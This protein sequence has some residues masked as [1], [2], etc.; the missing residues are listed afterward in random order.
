MIRESRC[1]QGTEVSSW[2]QTRPRTPC[3]RRIRAASVLA[4]RGSHQCHACATV[5]RSK[6][7]RGQPGLLGGALDGVHLRQGPAQLVQHVRGRVDGDHVQPAFG[8]EGRELPGAGSDVRGVLGPGGDQP[9]GR[10]RRVAGPDPVVVLAAVLEALPELLA[11]PAVQL[12]TAVQLRPL[13]Q[14]GAAACH[15]RSP[16]DRS[17][18][19]LRIYRTWTG[20]RRPAY[21]RH[22]SRGRRR[23]CPGCSVPSA[24]SCGVSLAGTQRPASTT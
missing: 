6:A 8:Q 24:G 2:F 19:Y 21:V 23:R 22:G 18:A 7:R 11:A 12:W 1:T 16:S 17:A 14:F 13:V 5:T 9:V 10:L 4:S 3:G 20:P 15:V